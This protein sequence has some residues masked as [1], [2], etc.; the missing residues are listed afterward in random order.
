MKAAA[1]LLAVLVTR[2]AEAATQKPS[3][4]AEWLRVAILKVKAGDCGTAQELLHKVLGKNPRSYAACNL[5]GLCRM[6][7]HQYEE[8]RSAFERSIQ[9]NLRY[10]P[11]H[12]NLGNALV[13]L[14]QESAALKEFLAALTLQPKDP[15]ALY[16]AGL[17][18]GRE[19]KFD[20][21]AKYL[22]QAHELSPD[23]KPVTLALVGAE[24]GRGKKRQAEALISRLEKEGSLD[25]PARERLAALWLE[26]S[27]PT[28]A[29]E[30]AQADSELAQRFYQLAYQAA[31]ADFDSGKFAQAANVLEAIRKLRS[32][33]AAFHDLLGSIYYALDSPQKASDEF[34]EAVRLAP[35]E[36][37]HYF[38]LGMVFLKHRTPDPA[39]YVFETAVKT[40]PDVSKLWLGL[41]LSYYF[42][43]RLQDAERALRRSI[44]IDPEYEIPYVVLGDLL[45]QSGRLDDALPVLR[46]AMEVRPDLYLPY[47][48]YGKLAL[49][50]KQE[51]ID[52]AIGMLRK[53]LALKPNFAEAHYELG[54]ALAEAGQTDEA[55]HE[56]QTSLHLN[57][58]LAP[59][60]YQL[61]MIYKK[62]GEDSRA[63]E[64]LRRFEAA[65]KKEK[66]EDLIR[67]LDF[68]IEKP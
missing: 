18:Y 31:A 26:N 37:E 34:Q 43:S 61:G 14:N 65:S 50:L 13:A 56:L 16:N 66:P 19:G 28:K 27:E 22:R 53:A 49:H 3:E 36:P 15:I 68:T 41:G 60:H 30:L 40:R 10:A 67:R 4:T 2:T 39:I 55:I 47:Y 35:S 64:H 54:K 17:L 45:E 1:S 33:N 63:S 25:V 44:A 8:A 12:V 11:A 29:V 32:P 24:L 59:S 52:E 21:A 62:L 7:D 46:K 23:D 42:A 51:K 9:I 6:Q 38:K 58:D 5:L 20:L 48:Y 57:P